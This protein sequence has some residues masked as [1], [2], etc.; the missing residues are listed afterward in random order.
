MTQFFLHERHTETL[1]FTLS[2]PQALSNFF[3]AGTTWNRL[4]FSA[5]TAKALWP[6][7]VKV[8]LHHGQGQGHGQGHAPGRS[9]G[10]TR[11]WNMFVPPNTTVQSKDGFPGR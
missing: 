6:G 10:W 2:E 11:K 8:N 1:E 9:A 5:D 7:L 3:V 4:T